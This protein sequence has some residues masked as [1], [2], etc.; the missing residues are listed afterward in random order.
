MEFESVTHAIHYAKGMKMEIVIINGNVIDVTQFKLCHPGGSNSIDRFLYQDCSVQYSNINSHKTKSAVRELFN[1]KIGTIKRDPNDK[2]IRED[3]KPTDTNYK[4]DLK[5]GTFYQ[6]MFKLNKEEYLAFCHDPKHMIDPPEAILF[7]TKFLEFFTKTPWYAIPLIWIPFVL[8]LLYDAN[9]LKS[10]PIMTVAISYIY[11]AFLWSLV[12]YFL[13]RWIFHID[14]LLPDNR[15]SLAIHYALHGI[16][17]AFPMDPNRLVF[18]PLL[19]VPLIYIFM[20]VYSSIFGIFSTAFFAGTLSGY[21]AYD[22]IHYFLHHVT[23]KSGYFKFLKK[24]HILHHYKDPHLGYGVSQHFWDKV[25][26]TVLISE[27]L[28]NK[29]ECNKQ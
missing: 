1:F 9:I 20:N 7:E 4:I 22:M 25:F 29:L 13:H 10:I 16:H 11:G 5:K 8:Y 21:I 17:H 28:G 23:P 26:D 24:Y 18:P 3:I 14:E 15:V 27:E 12:E 19:A 6:V 2:V